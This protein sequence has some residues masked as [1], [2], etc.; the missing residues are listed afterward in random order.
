MSNQFSVI[1]AF[2]LY[3]GGEYLH[4]GK[5]SKISVLVSQAHFKLS[6]NQVEEKM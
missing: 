2:T 3:V 4:T 6:L 1:V 5:V